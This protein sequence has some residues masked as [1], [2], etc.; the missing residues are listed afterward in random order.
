ME[1]WIDY[2]PDR[3]QNATRVVSY[4]SSMDTA[5]QQLDDENMLAEFYLTQLP[6]EVKGQKW[7][8]ILVDG[9]QGWGDGPGRGQSIYAALLLAK[10]TGF[11]YVDDCERPVEAAYVQR[12][13]VEKG[14]KKE[15]H[16]TNGH[17]G[18]TCVLFHEQLQQT[19]E[20]WD[21]CL[22]TPSDDQQLRGEVLDAI[23]GGLGGDKD[24]L[25]FGTGYDSPF[26]MASNPKGMTRFVED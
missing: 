3:V 6:E 11:V 21:S 16:D 18:T 19:Q 20:L 9:P 22:G 14:W 17:G 4:S 12:W 26:W 7:D 24:F 13:F 8:T 10:Q 2:Q 1:E 23:C 15:V 5:L 25:I